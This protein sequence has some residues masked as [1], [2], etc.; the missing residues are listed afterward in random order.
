M[1]AHQHNFNTYLGDEMYFNQ[2]SKY[3]GRGNVE[4]YKVFLCENCPDGPTLKRVYSGTLDKMVKNPGIPTLDE[5]IRATIKVEDTT[6]E[7]SS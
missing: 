3:T 4:L 5:K 6:K 1:E 2:Q 7:S